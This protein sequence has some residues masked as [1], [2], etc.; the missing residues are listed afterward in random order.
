MLDC[1]ET[2]EVKEYSNVHWFPTDPGNWH[3]RPDKTILMDATNDA[4]HT[5]VIELLMR[6]R[7]VMI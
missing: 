4:R 7:Q 2:S 5:L 1:R 3:S 6:K